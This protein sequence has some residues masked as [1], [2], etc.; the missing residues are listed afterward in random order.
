MELISIIVP[1]YNAEKYLDSCLNS[2]IN[3]SYNNL[4]IIM[5]NDG[6]KDNSVEII[7]K[8]CVRDER[9]KLFHQENQ[10]APAARNK[11]IIESQG[12]YLLFF[13]ADDVMIIDAVESLHNSIAKSDLVIG[14]FR[15]MIEEG[16]DIYRNYC[17]KK[18]FCDNTYY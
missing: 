7:E 17:N 10:G 6:S 4:E 11:G 15:Y 5:V 9:I 1:V 8:Y 16:K 18:L 12:K 2:I 14:S 13:D 3:Q